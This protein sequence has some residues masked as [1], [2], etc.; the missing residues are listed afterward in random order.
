MLG[1]REVDN[2]YQAHPGHIQWK[3]LNLITFPSTRQEWQPP[4]HT[5]GSPE[6][7]APPSLL[8]THWVGG[9]DR[10]GWLSGMALVNHAE[11]L[12]SSTIEISSDQNWS[13]APGTWAEQC[14]QNH[15]QSDQTASLMRENLL[16]FSCS[17]IP[18]FP[19]SMT[20]TMSN[21]FSFLIIF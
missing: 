12:S 7:P 17:I 5:R 10:V 1:D 3:C 14:T 4:H 9:R 11:A 18:A 16:S 21:S 13:A 19:L 6:E 20:K 15:P 2:D 8:N